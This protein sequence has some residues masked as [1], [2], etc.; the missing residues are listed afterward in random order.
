M[1]VLPF[2]P[3]M[4]DLLTC[5][6]Y[7][8]K[9]L[10]RGPSE[11]ALFPFSVKRYIRKGIP[12][13]HRAR[14]WMGV[15]GAQARM[16]RN[17]G[18]YQRLLQGERSASL[19]EAIRT[20]MNRTFPDNV[21]FRKDA[22]PCLQGPLYNVLLAYG[23]HNHGVGYCQ[24][25]NFI[26]G[27]LI[28][29]TKSEEEAFWLLDALVGRILP[30]GV[31]EFGELQR[32]KPK[33]LA[34]TATERDSRLLQPLDAGPEDGPGGARGAGADEAAGGGSADGRPRRAVDPGRVPLVH[35]PFRGRPA[36]GG[37]G[38]QLGPGPAARL[39]TD[40]PLPPQ[41]VLRVWD[42]LFSEGSKIIFRVALTL[43]KHHQASIL[44]ATSVPDLCEKFKEITR[45][46]FVTECHS[47]MQRV[48]SE[49]GS[50][51]RASI[52]RLRERCRAQLLAQG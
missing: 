14:V 8:W 2:M 4:S 34:A 37:E 1:P 7:P 47:F 28:L 10:E 52:A 16:D 22:E 33:S 5:E 41:T 32:T 18:Y 13:E 31:W 44:E 49:P 25:M 39:R 21:R 40:P 35:L 38:A 27:Y 26:A 43:L 19:E 3:F 17:P 23:H 36:R 9:P 29:V 42:C 50:L 48:F 24:G 30:G 15:S 6:S 46:R 45:G 20:D 51:S 11:T 12:L